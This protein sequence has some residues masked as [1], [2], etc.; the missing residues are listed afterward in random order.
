MR[1]FKESRP[2]EWIVATSQ[3]MLQEPSRACT[4]PRAAERL[5]SIVCICCSTSC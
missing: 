3:E 2:G 4:E 1:S 5:D